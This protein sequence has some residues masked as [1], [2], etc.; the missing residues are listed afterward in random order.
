M[1]ILESNQAICGQTELKS[2]TQHWVTIEKSELVKQTQQYAMVS[3]SVIQTS[4]YF[5]FLSCSA[6]ALQNTVCHFSP[7]L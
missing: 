6:C 5:S 4:R 1:Q 3:I 7:F 2:N